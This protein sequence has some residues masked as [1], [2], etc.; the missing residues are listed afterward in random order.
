MSVVCTRT[1]CAKGRSVDTSAHCYGFGTGAGWRLSYEHTNT[2]TVSR[3][4]PTTYASEDL[5]LAHAKVSNLDVA[6]GVEH[7]VVELEVTVDDTFLVQIPEA[8]EDL[9][10]VEA[11]LLDAKRALLLDVIPTQQCVHRRVGS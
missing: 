5:L 3:T 2:E 1:M 10:G 4:V 11:R 7:D 9:H 6:C 8:E